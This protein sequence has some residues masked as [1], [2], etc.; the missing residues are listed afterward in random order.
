[1]AAASIVRQ[2]PD[3]LKFGPGNRGGS[4]EGSRILGSASKRTNV[5]NGARG[6]TVRGGKQM[7]STATRLTSEQFL[8]GIFAALALRHWDR[9]S[10]RGGRFDRASAAAFVELERIAADYDVRPRFYVVSDTTYADS[11]VMRDAIARLA[12]WDLVS[13]DNPEFQDLRLK[14]SP[15]YADTVLSK[16]GLNKDMFNSLADQFVAAYEGNPPR[17]DEAASSPAGR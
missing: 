11:T 12:Q 2:L 10:I 7:T 14:I 8:A 6:A 1:M 3:M 17:V 15:T 13:L 16:L 4:R 9:I 5:R